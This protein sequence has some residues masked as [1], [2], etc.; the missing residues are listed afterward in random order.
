MH[1]DQI[2]ESYTPLNQVTQP[3]SG[4]YFKSQIGNLDDIEISFNKKE[5]TKLK[6]KCLD[7]L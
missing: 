6:V 2:M 1:H 7:F 5:V 3:F 4:P